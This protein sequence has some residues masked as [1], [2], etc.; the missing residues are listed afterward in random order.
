MGTAG[1][2]APSKPVDQRAHIWDFG[3][4]L[5]ELLTGRKLFT[6]ETVCDTLAAV[7]KDPI[8]VAIPQAKSP[9]PGLLRRCLSR[10][11]KHRLKDIGEA[12]GGGSR[13]VMPSP[14][15]PFSHC[16]GGTATEQ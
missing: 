13:G 15:Y 6:D 5:H 11:R 9:H 7:F 2:M 4:V 10:N 8:D 12:V 3:V 1:S 14:N 16:L